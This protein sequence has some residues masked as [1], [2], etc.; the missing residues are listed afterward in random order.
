MKFIITIVVIWN[1]ERIGRRKLLLYGIGT[2]CMGLLLLSIAFAGTNI[3]PN[4][5]ND[6]TNDNNNQ[7]S[8][9]SSESIA[10]VDNTTNSFYLALPG[11]LLVVCGYSMSYG[12]LTWLVTSE[13][14]PTDIRGRALGGSTIVT[15]ICA[16]LVTYTYLSATA[17]IGSS[18]VFSI[19]LFI[20]C[21]GWIFAYLAI[22]E[23]AGLNPDEIHHELNHMI[24]WNDRTIL[25][26]I[27]KPQTHNTL[28]TSE[29][30]HFATTATEIT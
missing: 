4:I 25:R 5:D 16:A 15:Y 19:Y 9:S 28:P 30:S 6:N 29:N 13:I 18:I 26:H 23:T 2:I 21:L 8:S 1:I 22:P 3:I 12:P 7:Q 24:W 27:T 14:F 11:V 10:Q 20:T 17:W